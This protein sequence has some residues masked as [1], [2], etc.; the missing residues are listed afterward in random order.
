M[1]QKILLF[2]FTL[3]STML[4]S[5]AVPMAFEDWKTTMGTQ[6]FFYKNVTKTD[7]SGNIYVA[8]ATVNGAGNTDILLAKYSSAGVQL[9]IQQY[10]GAGLGNDFAT[11]MFVTSNA[12]YLTGGVATSTASPTT[13]VI[14]MKYNLSGVLQWVSTYNGAG[15][16]FDAGRGLAYHTQSNTLY[17]SGGTYNTSLNSDILAIA[18]NSSGTQLWA[19]TYN[20]TS[21]LDDAGVKIAIGGSTVAVTGAVTNSTNNYKNATIT[22]DK[23]TGTLTAVNISTAV[24]TSSVNTVTDLVIDASNNYYVV[25]SS[26]VSGQGYNYYVQKLNSSL[27]TAWT[28]TYNGASNL[29]DIA[30]GVQVDA[31]G[32]VYITGYSTSSTQGRNIVTIKLNSS[33][34]NQWTQTI[35]GSANGDDEA[36]DMVLDVSANVYITGYTKDALNNKD[37]YTA[38]YNTSGTKLWEIQ[39]DGNHL[40][41]QSTNIALDSLTN[42]IVTGQTETTQNSFSFTTAK[43]LQKNIITPTDFNGESPVANFMFYQNKGQIVDTTHIVVSDVKFYTNNTNPVFYFKN[44]SQSF[45][46]AK[47]D[48]AMVNHKDTLQRIDLN[49][50]NSLE[51]AKT[52]PLEQQK[53]GYLNYFVPQAGSGGI[54][55]VFGNKRLITTNLY[56]NIDLMTTSNQNGIKYYFIVK[57][58]GDMRDIKL[59]FSGATSYSLNG[60]TNY[61]SINSKI[62]KVTFDKP[63]AYQLTS[64]NSTVAITSFSPTWTV[65]GASNKYKFN[66]GT[67]T[68]S[69]TL[70][71]EVDQGNSVIST[72]TNSLNCEWST[73]V[74]GS[75]NE[76][77]T[78]VKSDANSNLFVSGFTYSSNF[79]PAGL[80]VF[81]NYNNGSYDGFMDKYDV[82]GTRVWSTYIGGTED[83]NIMGFDIAPNG[84]IYMVGQTTSTLVTLGKAGATNSLTPIGAEDFFIF[85]MSTDAQQKKWL[86]YYGGNAKD[87]Y[88]TCKFDANGNFFMVGRTLSKNL[89][90]LGSTPQYTNTNHDVL[91]TAEGFIVRYN[92]SSQITWA[93]Y[94]G[95][96]NNGTLTSAHDGL[97]D[98]DFDSNNDLYVIGYAN[99]TDFPN[100]VNGNSTNFSHYNALVSDA[101]ISHFSNTGQIKWST[102]MGSVTNSTFNAIKIKNNKIYLTGFK[103]TSGLNFPLKN[104]GNWYYSTASSGLTDAIFTIFNNKDSLLHSTYIAGDDWQVGEDIDVDALG[105]V[106]ISGKTESTVFPASVSQAPNTYIQSFNGYND[107]FIFALEPGNTNIVWATNI[108]GTNF[109]G[110]VLYPGG[111]SID[112]NQL[113]MLHLA[114]STMS[115]TLFPLYSGTVGVTYFDGGFNSGVDVSITRFNLHPINFVGIKENQ[116][117][118]LAEFLIYPNPTQSIINVKLNA[119]N[120]HT[121]YYIY[122]TL[123]QAVKEGV[124]EKNIEINPIDLSS[125]SHGL[126]ILE[127]K[128]KD[129]KAS[130]KFVK[131]D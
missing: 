93:T 31:S 101:T 67:Y 40:N 18:Y 103:T 92:S 66:N 26:L 74:G 94:L 9:W 89:P 47:N 69:L 96:S 97:Q 64:T 65:D 91:S 88:I 119:T 25:G 2:A 4:F 129:K 12:I 48:T 110:S 81:Q 57:P 53:N 32:N 5:Q 46:F 124:F 33:G 83:D 112:I 20:Y 22:F 34:T 17:V 79:P 19:N 95:S 51:S 120:E 3:L 29:D 126:Y 128:Q 39:T 72:L 87:D 105:K 130:V 35:N 75:N 84:E 106:Y 27:I 80:Y 104:S 131:H 15:N 109:D 111:S 113:N 116:K 121:F 44:R 36:N 50:T 54:T 16:S 118:D 62:G 125:L 117:N 7:L 14:T 60:A 107:M 21:N 127:V 43:Y 71:I 70:V 42:V 56:N 100:T 115:N 8:G 58:G 55:G 30:K 68:S 77:A 38:K 45:V 13:D 49:F 6:N 41:D 102:C 123:G 78:N 1:K 11:D 82:N 76:A 85:Q 90:I 28:Y 59:E 63:V 52:Y 108:G 114:G 98:L 24:T 122:N 10:A 61:L 99:G 73:Y 86:T 37:Y 23:T